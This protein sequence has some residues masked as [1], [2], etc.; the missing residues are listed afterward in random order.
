MKNKTCSIIRTPYHLFLTM[1]LYENKWFDGNLSILY[2]ANKNSESLLKCINNLKN[3]YPEIELTPFND[4]NLSLQLK[5]KPLSILFLKKRF[6]LNSNDYPNIRTEKFLFFVSNFIEKFIQN[7]NKKSRFILIEDGEAI[8]QIFKEANLQGIVKKIFRLGTNNDKFKI[9]HEIW[10]QAPERIKMRHNALIRKINISQLMNGVKNNIINDIF[11][12]FGF[13]ES[14]ISMI[15][16]NSEINRKKVMLLT[17]CF[18]ENNAITEDTKISYYKR[19][20]DQYPDDIIIIKPHPRE[21]TNYKEIFKTVVQIPNQFPV[22]IL[23]Y[24]DSLKIDIGITINSSSL[25]N[26]SFINEKIVLGHE[27]FEELNNYYQKLI[28]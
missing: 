10:C 19:I 6:W 9:A 15:M 8:Y 27:K 4:G 5:N 16:Q 25:N 1:L 3:I 12:V 18:S 11:K 26:C 20:V 2:F 24:M 22:E 14:D 13:F 23:N 21:K 7:N 28:K 17:Q